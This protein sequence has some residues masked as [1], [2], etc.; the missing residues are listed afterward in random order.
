MPKR[1]GQGETKGDTKG[2]EEKGAKEGK[3]MTRLICATI[4]NERVDMTILA[5]GIKDSRTKRWR[6]WVRAWNMI[7]WATY[8]RA[9]A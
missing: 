1:D 7:V 5:K 4:A 9:K 2:R 3:G 8:R 6:N